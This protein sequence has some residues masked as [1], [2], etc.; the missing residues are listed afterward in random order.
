MMSVLLT[1]LGIAGIWVLFNCV[2]P[3]AVLVQA[4]RISVG[5]L[6]PELFLWPGY[7]RVRFYLT[8]L[9]GG[10]GYSVWAP[11]LNIVI[12]DRAFFAGASPALIRYVVAHELAH[13]SL[14]HHRKRW[15]LVVCGLA[16]LPAIRRLF[17]RFEAEADAEAARRT[18]FTRQVFKELQQVECSSDGTG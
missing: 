2:A 5:R 4:E 10:Y 16:L 1:F 14:G 15:L 9:Q 12:F 6:P 7:R 3:Y 13:F 18:G 8:A 11:P 17:R